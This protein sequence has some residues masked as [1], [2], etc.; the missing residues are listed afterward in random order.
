MPVIHCHYQKNKGPCEHFGKEQRYDCYSSF[1]KKKKKG[2]GEH[3]LDLD[4]TDSKQSN[5]NKKSPFTMESQT[6]HN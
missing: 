2:K 4:T 6:L 1:L 3:L 5:N